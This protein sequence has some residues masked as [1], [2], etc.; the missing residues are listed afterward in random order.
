MT[1]TSPPTVTQLPDGTRLRVR[2]LAPADAPQI[3]EGFEHLSQET[4]R[5]RFLGALK[6]LP[7]NH[8][9]AITHADAFQHVVWG[10][11]V[12]D[13]L[14][15]EKGIG[16]AHVIRDPADPTRGEFAIVIADE[17]QHH[18]AGKVLTR[19]LAARL[20][21]IGIPIW[22]ATMYLDNRAVQRL[23]ADV[24]DEISRTVLSSGVGEII[25]RLRPP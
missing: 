16:V 15:R 18:G 3:L 22:T 7:P 20:L 25:Y 23:L 11:A 14:D 10:V 8:E 5:R 6:H 12:L 24:G 13:E 2:P 4:R 1:D 19:A 17:W 9:H 21:A